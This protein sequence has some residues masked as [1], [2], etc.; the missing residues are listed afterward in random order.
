[1]IFRREDSGAFI[2]IV[3]TEPYKVEKKKQRLRGIVTQYCLLKVKWALTT[4]IGA[5]RT[6][7]W[8]LFVERLRDYIT[9]NITKCSEI[10]TRHII[11][12]LYRVSQKKH[13]YKIYVLR[14]DYRLP[15]TKRVQLDM[16]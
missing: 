1:M 13:S 9:T 8:I 4:Y 6:F 10:K 16:N 12:E 14:S 2:S 11:D 5:K 15:V 7:P 3:R